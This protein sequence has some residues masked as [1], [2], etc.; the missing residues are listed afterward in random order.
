M[1]ATR[2]GRINR[3]H[4]LG[5][6]AVSACPLHLLAQETFP[7]RSIRLIVPFAAGGGTDILARL[8][9]SGMSTRLGQQVVVENLTGAGG[10][11]GAMQV[12]RSTPDG[13]TLMIGT[14]GSILSNSAM[15][16]DLKY[17][18][19]NDF[20]PI[21]KFSDSPVVLIANK[22]HDELTPRL[23]SRPFHCRVRT[24]KSPST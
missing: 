24:K 17:S 20:I 15:Q 16:P 5:A 8:L 14:P 6:M 4:V 10:T 3:R 1:T 12:A 19:H 7:S 13:H 18:A 9:A 11:I 21:S 2:I 23:R 22:E